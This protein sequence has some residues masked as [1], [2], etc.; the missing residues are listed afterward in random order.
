M[1]LNWGSTR[2]ERLFVFLEPL[3]RL[4]TVANEGSSDGED[5]LGLF[6]THIDFELD[7]KEFA[8]N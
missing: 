8:R 6:G 7:M 1:E 2:A 3:L 4:V 5:V